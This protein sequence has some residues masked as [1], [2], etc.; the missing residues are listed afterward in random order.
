MYNNSGSSGIRVTPENAVRGDVDGLVLLRL[1]TMDA[2]RRRGRDF[3]QILKSRP[4]HSAVGIE[5]TAIHLCFLE[6]PLMLRCDDDST[7][8]QTASQNL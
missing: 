2:D 6:P 3:K 1:S 8:S 7:T 4:H 5:S